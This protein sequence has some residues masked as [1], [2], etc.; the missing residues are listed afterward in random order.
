[1]GA[2]ALVTVVEKF[3]ECHEVGWID[4]IYLMDGADGVGPMDVASANNPWDHP[5][6]G[7]CNR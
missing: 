4:K 5:V 2:R 7:K 3:T 6:F 1:M